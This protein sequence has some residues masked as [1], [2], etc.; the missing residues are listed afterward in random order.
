MGV[1]GRLTWRRQAQNSAACDEKI[2]T[3]GAL[4]MTTFQQNRARAEADQG[5]R[6]LQHRY[7]GCGHRNVQQNRRFGQ[8]GSEESRHGQQ[9][10]A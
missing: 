7:L 1:G 8:V 4:G 6:L 3:F 5:L 9:A 10:P 2:Y